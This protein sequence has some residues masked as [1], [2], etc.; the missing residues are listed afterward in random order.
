MNIEQVRDILAKIRNVKVAIYGDYCLDGYW[1]LGRRG[2]EIAVESG[3]KAVAVDKQRYLPG[4]AASVAANLAALEPDHII[5]VGVVGDDLFGRELMRQMEELGVDTTRMTVQKENFATMTYC[6]SFADGMERPRMDFGS[7]SRRSS[8]TDLAILNALREAFQIADFVIVNQQVPG[9]IADPAFI[10]GVNGLIEEFA[11]KRVLVDSRHYGPKFRNACFRLNEREAAIFCGEKFNIGERPDVGQVKAQ[12]E[13][14]FGMTNKPVF[15]TRGGRGIVVRDER[16]TYDVPGVQVLKRI[17]PVGAG[18]TVASALAC[19]LS[20][21]TNS[22]AAAEF[23]GLAA[24]VTAQ[25][26]GETGTASGAEI[27]AAAWEIDYVHHPEL[28]EDESRAVLLEDSDIEI[29]CDRSNL[30]RSRISHV[31]FDNDGTISVLRQ[32]WE[33]VMELMMVRA[34]LGNRGGD[35]AIGNRVR[36]RVRD[37]VNKT[38]GLPTIVQMEGLVD[39]VREFG[40]VPECDILDESGYRDMF[41]KVMK[42]KVGERLLRLNRGRLAPD[43]FIIKGAINFLAMLRERKFTLYLA[44]GSDYE[45]LV[46]EAEALGYAR[47]FNGGIYGCMAGSRKYSKKI[48]IE[49]ILRDNHIEGG[50]LVCFGDGPVEIRA[51]KKFGGLAVG[52]ASDEVRRHG[53]KSDKRTRLIKCGADVIVPDFSEAG[54]MMSLVFGV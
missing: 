19:C 35:E 15:I 45:D 14:I 27:I 29:C 20:A 8:E 44:G 10:E 28:A 49:T 25:K 12:A 38:T 31:L 33:K 41:M 51:C 5:A 24:I 3:L 16:G 11:S 17:D 23:A 50:E 32:G 37:F 48:V 30:P 54:T 46:A 34:V 7:S 53:V 47:M 18:D 2:S 1:T 9:S 42:G 6:K 22:M 40:L 36:H 21:G 43:D 26:L 52:V 39:M 4:G 13:K